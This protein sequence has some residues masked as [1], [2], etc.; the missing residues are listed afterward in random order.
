MLA[1]AKTANPT[2]LVAPHPQTNPQRR[3]HPK[4]HRNMHGSAHR[5]TP[6]HASQH[7]AQHTRDGGIWIPCRIH[8]IIYQYREGLA[9]RHL[10]AMP[11]RQRRPP[12]WPTHSSAWPTHTQPRCLAWPT[13][14][15]PR[16]SAWPT[17]RQ[18]HHLD[19]SFPMLCGACLCACLYTCPYAAAALQSFRCQRRS[20]RGSRGSRRGSCCSGRSCRR[21]YCCRSCCEEK[22]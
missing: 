22:V 17:F 15:Q 1:S 16:C 4:C 21:S 6:Q 7:T 8:E 18:P 2:R 20:S 14:A 9:L 13:H 3:I 10:H 11:G 12:A 19:G 5:S